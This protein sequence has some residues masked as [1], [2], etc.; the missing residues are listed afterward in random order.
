MAIIEETADRVGDY[1]SV[2][3]DVLLIGGEKS[4]AFLARSLDA[5]ETVL[6]N[7][8]RINLPGLG[9]QAAVDQPDR[10]AAVL[11]ECFKG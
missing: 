4:P 11:R 7:C 3:A 2:Q 6:P 10:V 1:A 8:R 9:H 5:L